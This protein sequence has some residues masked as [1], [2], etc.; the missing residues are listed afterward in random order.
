MRTSV[1]AELNQL[2]HDAGV[3]PEID[4]IDRVGAEVP[5]GF[6]DLGR[7]FVDDPRL[8]EEDVDMRLQSH[9]A[10]RERAY[11]SFRRTKTHMMIHMCV[12]SGV[13]GEWGDEFE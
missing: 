2:R 5:C 9:S 1:M 8:D 3:E 10:G 12:P 11:A 6:D 13:G 7:F 4:G